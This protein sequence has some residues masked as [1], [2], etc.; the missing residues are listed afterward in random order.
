MKKDRVRNDSAVRLQNPSGDSVR[1][2]VVGK[3]VKFYQ[4]AKGWRTIQALE[5][6]LAH[7]SV[8]GHIIH[9]A[10]NYVWT[11]GWLQHRTGP[12]GVAEYHISPAGSQGNVR[13]QH[14]IREREMDAIV[15]FFNDPLHANRNDIER[16]EVAQQACGRVS[17][18]SKIFLASWNELI[19][20]GVIANV[21]SPTTGR[22][23]KY[24]C[25]V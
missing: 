9:A 19:R 11:R 23:T 16:D 8:R 21:P 20:R 12:N 5:D 24:Y 7:G 3:I 25:L 14:D 6:H 15:M 13:R 17:A 4:D 10:R 1:A 2:V 22:R 18:R